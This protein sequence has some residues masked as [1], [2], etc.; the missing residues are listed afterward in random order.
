MQLFIGS[1]HRGYHVKKEIKKKIDCV[2]VNPIQKDT[3]DYPTVARDVCAAIQKNKLNG[4]GVLICGTG[5]GMCIT[6]NKHTGI[7]AALCKT[8]EEVKLCR[9]HNLANVLCLPQNVYNAAGLVEVF[10]NTPTEG[11]EARHLKRVAMLE[12]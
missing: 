10:L 8:Q 4:L 6:A 3:Y 9:V 11:I 12:L 1:D 7:R 5:I 2:D